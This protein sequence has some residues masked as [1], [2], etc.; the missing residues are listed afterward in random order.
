MGSLLSPF[1][2]LTLLATQGGMGYIRQLFLRMGLT[3]SFLVCSAWISAQQ[4]CAVFWSTLHITLFLVLH[5]LLLVL[6]AYWQ[7]VWGAG[8]RG[9]QGEA[10]PQGSSEHLLP[11]GVI[12]PCALDWL[13]HC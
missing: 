1:W 3:S 10:L 9:G 4:W 12:N 13:S 11:G 8:L 6:L 7:Q 2:W 5:G